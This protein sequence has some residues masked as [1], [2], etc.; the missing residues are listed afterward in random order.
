MMF[1]KPR[2]VETAFLEQEHT[3]KLAHNYFDNDLG[4]HHLLPISP[5]SRYFK[6][7][8]WSHSPGH[9]P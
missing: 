3:S 1:S 9:F 7:I 6:I 8:P 2:T 5:Q 4:I